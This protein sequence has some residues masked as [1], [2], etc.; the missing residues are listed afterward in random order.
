[1]V[2]N[3]MAV[4]AST[5]GARGRSR[6]TAPEGGRRKDGV[7]IKRLPFHNSEKRKAKSEK[8]RCRL[9]RRIG[10]TPSAPSGHLPLRGRLWQSF[11]VLPMASTNSNRFQALPMASTNGNRFL[12]F[13]NGP[14]TEGAVSEADWGSNPIRRRQPTPSLFA[15]R[16]SLFAFRFS[17]FAVMKGQS[18][19][20][21]T[22]LP[23]PSLRYRLRCRLP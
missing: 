19:Y 23:S 18:F 6:E 16:F 14:L 15:F 9:R 20:E 11:Q 2:I 22:N 21:N 12:G 4:R 17:L 8:R 5:T 1:M 7:F 3:P 13:A 10:W